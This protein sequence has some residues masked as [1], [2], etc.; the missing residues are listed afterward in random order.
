VH[1]LSLFITGIREGQNID[2]E[3]LGRSMLPLPPKEEQKAIAKFL[4][5]EIREIDS[6]IGSYRQLVGFSRSASERKG[7]LLFE[8]RTRLIADVVTGK[9]D[10]RKVAKDLPD[11][12]MDLGIHEFNF[13]EIA[14]GVEEPPAPA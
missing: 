5:Q 12:A 8:Y 1:N 14:E 6:L 7:S 2:Y 10:V 13:D 3:R 4:R 9:L 11:E